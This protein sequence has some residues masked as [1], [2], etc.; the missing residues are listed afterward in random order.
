MYSSSFAACR[1]RSIRADARSNEHSS[2][3]PLFK[4]P[5]SKEDPST[6]GSS[7]LCGWLDKCFCF[8]Y[9]VLCYFYLANFPRIMLFFIFLRIGT[10]QVY[11]K[12]ICDFFVKADDVSFDRTLLYSR[13]KCGGSLKIGVDFQMDFVKPFD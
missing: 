7:G 1:G 9:S 10:E 8:S 3:K 11:C 2:W 12:K 13:M 5:T 4:Q 6:T